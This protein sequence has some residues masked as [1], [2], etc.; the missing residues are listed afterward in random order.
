MEPIFVPAPAKSAFNKNRRVSDLLISQLKHFQHVEKKNG[1]EIHPALA[2]D[3]HTEAG[4]ARY[5]AQI[6]RA[7]RAQAK[8]AGIAAVPAVPASPAKP[9][10]PA[11][12]KSGLALAASAAK[13][14]SGKPRKRKKS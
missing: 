13:A 1:I 10:L 7:I 14:P 9:K 6:T 11:A 4:A 8:P 2:A 12:P 3:I 5:I